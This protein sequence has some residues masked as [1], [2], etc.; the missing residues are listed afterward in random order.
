M[1]ISL[2]KSKKVFNFADSFF[3][4]VFDPLKFVDVI[5]ILVAVLVLLSFILWLCKV[6]GGSIAPCFGFDYVQLFV[7]KMMLS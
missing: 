7:M 5:V 4:P 2:S 6:F 1:L 3:V